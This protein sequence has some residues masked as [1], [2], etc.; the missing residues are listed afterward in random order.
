M[1]SSTSFTQAVPGGTGGLSASVLERRS[2]RRHL[3]RR[4]WRTSRRCHSLALKACL[5]VALACFAMPAL[6]QKSDPTPPKRPSEVYVPS[7]DLDA[8]LGMEKRSVLLPRAQFEELLKKAEQNA[9]E[10]PDV[11]NGITVISADYQGRIVGSQ[12]LIAATIKLNQVTE[13]WRFLRL[14]LAGVGLESAAL[15]GKPALLGAKGSDP[16]PHLFSDHRG[17]HTLLFEA[18]VPLTVSGGEREATFRLGDLPVGTLSLEVPANQRLLVSGRALERPSPIDKP[19]TYSIAVGGSAEIH[20]KLVDRSLEQATDRLLFG[21]TI[22]RLNV[23]LGDAAW[24]AVTTLDARGRRW[25]S[26]PSGA[27]KACGSRPSPRR[28]STRGSWRR[29]RRKNRPR[30]NWRFVSRS[31]ASGRSSFAACCGREPTVAGASNRSRSTA[32]PPTWDTSRSPR[33]TTCGC[34]STRRPI[35]GPGRSPLRLPTR[36]P[37][38]T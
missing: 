11:P 5:V 13:G 17:P 21:T 38:S 7:S 6:A 33:R 32:Q 12:L 15:D 28:G 9:R 16:V 36:R 29:P 10:T 18:A 8:I 4:H 31:P 37:L 30:S 2:L 24:Q 34:G 19:A 35:C 22:Y 23:S 27:P 26:S 3:R 20:L 25:A 1:S 14:P